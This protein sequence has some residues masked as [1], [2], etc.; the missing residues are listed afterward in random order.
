MLVMSKDEARLDK[1]EAHLLWLLKTLWEDDITLQCCGLPLIVDEL[2]RL[3]AS[4]PRAKE[5]ITPFVTRILGD[6][7][8]L[9][10]CLNQ[11]N[12]YQPWA[13][14]YLPA[15]VDRKARLEQDFAERFR[16]EDPLN[17]AMLEYEKHSPRALAVPSGKK[18]DY[19]A[20]KRRNA[21]NVRQLRFAEA[22]L[23]VFWAY[24]DKIVYAKTNGLQGLALKQ[25]LSEPRA[26]QRTPEWVQVSKPARKELEASRTD[27]VSEPHWL[28]RPIS[29]L[30]LGSSGDKGSSDHAAIP[31]T[32]VKTRGTTDQT[33]TPREPEGAAPVQPAQRTFVVDAR[34]F[35]VFRIIFFNPNTST[36]P[37]EVAWNDFLH[38]LV[39]TGFAAQKLY[40]SVWH[41]E[42][43]T[44]DVERSIQ[45]HEPHPK[46][47]LS[48]YTARRYG[49]RLNRAY[50]WS[51][52]MFVPRV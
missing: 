9:A 29:S 6:M 33:E 39:S 12:M 40:G 34:A 1:V 18:F 15:L 51:G 2:D 24:I 35:K 25:V 45:F 50:G 32:K 10:E 27:T 11:I 43:R 3:L 22:N 42:P 52:A 28:Y 8:I 21:E 30:D 19:P 47:K 41:F 16:R 20:N 5:L 7:S 48:F 46:G 38:A 44:L 13:N 23:D 36:T 31:K 49:R 4:D 14:G 26:L 17:A 37:G